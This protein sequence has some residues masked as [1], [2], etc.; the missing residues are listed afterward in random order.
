MAAEAG[1]VRIDRDGRQLELTVRSQEDA[2]EKRLAAAFG[3]QQAESHACSLEDIFT[4]YMGA[5]T[6]RGTPPS[7]SP[8]SIGVARVVGGQLRKNLRKA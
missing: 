3:A 7:Y 5:E 8:E 6:D 4:A 2:P 1:V